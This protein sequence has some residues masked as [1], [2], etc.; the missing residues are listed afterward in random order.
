V[1]D[2][3]IIQTVQDA[4][5]QVIPG[6]DQGISLP[7]GQVVTLIETIWNAPGP[8]GLVSRFR[9]LAPAINPATT[10]ETGPVEFEN[11]AKDIAWLCENFA[12]QQV[13]KMGPAPA[14]VVVSMSDRLVPF[15]ETDPEA[16]QFFEAFRIENGTCIWEML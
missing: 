5:G 15:G 9:F 11:A 10:A 7:S 3:G 6:D 12:L 14:Q 2:K 16:V 1:A 13:A 4:G 8:D